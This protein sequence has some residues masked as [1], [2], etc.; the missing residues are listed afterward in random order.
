MLLAASCG[1][2]MQL[3][4]LMEGTHIIGGNYQWLGH[5]EFL[6][7]LLLMELLV[8]RLASRSSTVVSEVPLG[9]SP[10]RHA[11]RNVLRLM[12]G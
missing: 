9:L 4:L 3:A 2:L 10:F 6:H 11:S 5:F 8:L 7:R 12:T 1:Q